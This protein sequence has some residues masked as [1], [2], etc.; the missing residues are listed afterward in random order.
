LGIIS[1]P[2]SNNQPEGPFFFIAQFFFHLTENPPATQ[3]ASLD[4]ALRFRIHFCSLDD[5][6]LPQ[7]MGELFA[8]AEGHGGAPNEKKKRAPKM[9]FLNRYQWN[10]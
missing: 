6:V 5:H 9:R 8:F 1:S 4:C 7:G 3:S 10:G 2:T